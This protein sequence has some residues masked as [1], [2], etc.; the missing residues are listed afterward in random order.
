MLMRKSNLAMIVLL[1]APAVA[2]AFPR[3]P[4]TV[5]KALKLQQKME[6]KQ[7]KRQ[8]KAW[9]RSVRRDHIPRAERLAAEHRFNRQMA[10]LKL[11]QK[12][13]VQRQKDHLRVLKS[14][15]RHVY[16]GGTTIQ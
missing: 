16:L 5:L 7:L 1:T 8:E 9:K 2:F 6:R 11:R 14:A 15:Q 13:Q 10:E 4:L 3:K 12:E